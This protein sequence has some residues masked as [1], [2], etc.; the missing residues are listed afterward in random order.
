MNG[1][2]VIGLGPMGQAMTSAFLRNGISTTV[3]NRTAGR[4]DKVVSEGAILA[5]TVADALAANKLVILSLTDYKAMY[6]ILSN[7]THA[8][9]G[10]VLVNLSSDTPEKARE[11]SKWA[12][13]AG[14]EFLSGG[15]MVT[16]SM[17]GQP[18]SFTFF[19]GPKE[20]FDE[21]EHLLKIIGATDY[22][23]SDPMLAPL[24]YQ[25]LLD[26]MFTS[27]A[28]IMHAIAL[29]RS[30]NVSGKTFEPYLL[31]FLAFMPEL[32]R[33]LSMA[34]EADKGTYY[35]E[36]NNMNMM[37]AGIDHITHASHDAGINTSLPAL[38]RDIYNK[39]VALGHGKDG[40]ASIIEVLKKP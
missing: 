23:G 37:A 16:P 34:E 32:V 3:W 20:V 19:S 11:A 22:R 21:Q 26:I 5:P 29:M 38:I 7:F 33:D 10:R 40:L 27:M 39:T 15:I 12:E 8:L 35:G 36:L 1:V 24:Y 6:D 25:A 18:G 30:G 31:N 28:G 17:I 14:A 4:A 9:K 13:V 2:T